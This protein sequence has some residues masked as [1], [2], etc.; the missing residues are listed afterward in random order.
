MEIAV[1]EQGSLYLAP[2]LSAEEARGHAGHYR[3]SAFGGLT[4]LFARPKP[5]DIVVQPLGLRYEPFWHVTAHLRVAYERR[6]SYRFPISVPE[7]VVSVAI[8]NASFD[9][10]GE[11]KE[12]GITVTALAQCV[13]QLRKELWIDAVTGD[14]IAPRPIDAAEPI[15]LATFAPAGASI[16]DPTVR[17]SAVIRHVLGDD[18]K[19]PEADAFHEERA[20]IDALDLFFWP[21]YAFDLAW[22]AKNK[23]VHITVNGRTGEIVQAKSALHPAFAKLLS[24]ETLFDIGSETLNLVVPGGAI[25]LKIVRALRRKGA[26]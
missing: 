2:S 4:Q 9:L 8:G 11:R 20:E 6:E 22:A 18:V 24:R 26:E 25:P 16:V 5:D 3:T 21:L 23:T 19:P 7:H 12:R 14:P 10:D 17:A 15:D 1:A 13:R